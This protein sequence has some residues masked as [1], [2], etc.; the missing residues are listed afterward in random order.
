[1]KELAILD[2]IV[3]FV[4][5][6]FIVGIGFYFLRRQKTTQDYF[7]ANRRIPGWAM[8]IGLIA[9]L[10]SNITF[11]ANPA[12]AF[13]GDW[14]QYLNSF[15]VIIVMF[16]IAFIVIPLYRNVIGMSLYEFFE[17]RFG[18]GIRAYG[19]VAFSLYY[20]SRMGVIFFVLSLA[21]NTM[22]GW[23]IF[24][25]ITI[26]GIA[27]II[28]TL[29][30]GIEAVTWT[31]V[32]QGILLITG[33]L[34]CLGIA[35][36][37]INTDAG[38]IFQSAWDAGKFR[39]GEMSWNLER[40]TV[41]VMVLY[42]IYQHGHNFG[43]DQT[44]VQRYLTARSTKQAT[45][46]ALVSGLACIPVWGMF[47]LMGTALWGFYKFSGHTLPQ[48]V[49]ND[50]DK[51]FPY[52]IMSQL[53]VGVTGL[54]LAGLLSSAMST[55]SSGLNSFSAVLTRDIYSKIKPQNSNRRQLFVA[56]ILVG[57]GGVLSLSLAAW[58]TTLSEQVLV[59]YYSALSI[60]AGGILG[61]YL[62]AVFC[63]RANLKG[64]T[65]G[66][67]SAILVVSWAALTKNNIIDLGPLNY[68]LHQY[69]IGLW[70]H[71]AVLVVGY[72]VSLFFP[73]EEVGLK[74]INPLDR[75]HIRLDT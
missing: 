51:V 62:L 49:V 28:Y 9:T 20:I 16:P 27:T 24:G 36:F 30:G 15:M 26:L 57:V 10:V 18:Y 38:Q 19:A 34:V 14:V 46:S 6:F 69:L 43:T 45:R 54:I 63:R 1:M 72:I 22:T 74:Y 33:A 52:F 25:I 50:P 60:F 21:I 32:I 23:D 39:M 48:E 4:Y 12:V 73:D 53:P 59:I 71:L 67:I 42:G 31:D 65:A 66:I 64:A 17:Q 75:K 40:D 29:S 13:E 5:M 44:M 37:S 61:L 2:Y 70:S 3:L 56:R 58:L 35:L 7:I 68:D 47:F 41:L 8:G 11:L 55:L